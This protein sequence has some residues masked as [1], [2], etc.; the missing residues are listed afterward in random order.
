M[1]Y[2]NSLFLKFNVVEEATIF[3]LTFENFVKTAF[4][5][6]G[7][8]SLNTADLFTVFQ[9]LNL[10]FV[11]YS[12]QF[13]GNVKIGLQTYHSDHAVCGYYIVLGFR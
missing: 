3:Y 8:L 2:M 7:N 6:S 10:N 4:F 11:M 13:V 5:F 9:K 12:R 1:Q